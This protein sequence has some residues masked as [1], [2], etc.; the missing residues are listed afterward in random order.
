MCLYLQSLASRYMGC[1]GCIWWADFALT[2]HRWIIGVKSYV[3]PHRAVL[4]PAI[5]RTE[6]SIVRFLVIKCLVARMWRTNATVEKSFGWTEDDC[7][8]HVPS[9]KSA[10]KE[11]CFVEVTKTGRV[12]DKKHLH[13]VRKHIMKDI[14][15]SRR[16]K[17]V[18]SEE[19]CQKVRKQNRHTVDRPSSD[20]SSNRSS[21]CSV[22][23]AWSL[24]SG[25]TDPFACYP[26]PVDQDLL[27]LID[28]GT[29]EPHLV[30]SRH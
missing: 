14:G 17:I 20:L 12:T 10:P 13:N 25:R 26:I 2:K 1:L 4:I 9:P 18:P 23:G 27:F 30:Q 6:F 21:H 15:K 11:F 7:H 22:F 3:F 24:G 5:Y 28:H 16:K 19:S 8:S 29:Q